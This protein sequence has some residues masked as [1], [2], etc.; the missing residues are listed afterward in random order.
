MIKMKKFS[1][2]ALLLALIVTLTACG[3]KKTTAKEDESST[4]APVSTSS[5]E[6]TENKT[7]D[8]TT[9]DNKAKDP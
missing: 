6:N 8:D 3:D 4:N 7:E 1:A 5:T 9:A 2:I